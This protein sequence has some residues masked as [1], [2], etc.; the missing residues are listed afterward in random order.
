MLAGVPIF[1]PLN[2]EQLSGLAKLVVRRVFPPGA[3][4]IRE[5]DNDAALYIIV[6]GEVRVSTQTGNGASA[7]HLATLHAGAFIGEMALLDGAPRSATCTAISQTECLVL[8]RWVFNTTLRSDPLIAVAMLPVL[9]RRVREAD[10]ATRKAT[11]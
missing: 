4:I 6:N 3:V 1:A 2:K 8:T 7:L 9:S 5:G 10:E 11:S